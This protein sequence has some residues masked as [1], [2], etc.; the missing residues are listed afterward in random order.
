MIFYNFKSYCFVAT[1]VREWRVERWQLFL[2]LLMF[3]KSNEFRFRRIISEESTTV[4]EKNR[5]WPHALL[6][7]LWPTT[8]Q[9]DLGSGHQLHHLVEKRPMA[10]RKLWQNRSFNRD[11]N[12]NSVLLNICLCLPIFQQESIRSRT[13]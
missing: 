3:L 4:V 11:R 7:P 2:I 8:R 9:L 13:C 6:K 10:Y 1:E 12:N 5:R